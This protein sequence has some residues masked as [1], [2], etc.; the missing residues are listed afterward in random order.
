MRN[1]GN[2]GLMYHWITYRTGKEYG[3]DQG[4]TK[5]CVTNAKIPL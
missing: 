2:I 4:N 5:T 3:R 1:C